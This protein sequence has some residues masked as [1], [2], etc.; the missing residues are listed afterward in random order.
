MSDLRKHLQAIY[1]ER[2]KLTPTAVVEEAQDEAHPL[3]SH[4]EWDDSIAGHRY[5]LQQGQELIRSVKIVYRESD[6]K[7]SSIRAWTSIR[8]DTGY[9]YEPTEEVIK[10]DIK[11][12]IVLAEMKREWLAFK[13]RYEQFGEFRDLILGDLNA[14]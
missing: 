13:R 11:T 4:F 6:G 10:D 5:R 12:K 8:K 7:P 14:A 3:H 1:D 2:G 9:T